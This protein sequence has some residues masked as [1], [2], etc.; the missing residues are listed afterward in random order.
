MCST[1]PAPASPSE[2]TAA[3]STTA[4]AGPGQCAAHRGVEGDN[5]PGRLLPVDC[6][7]QVGGAPSGGFSR[8]PSAPAPAPRPACTAGPAQ[9]SAHWHGSTGTALQSWNKTPS[10]SR[11][12][13]LG[14]VLQQPGALLRVGPPRQVAVQRNN[15]SA[16]QVERVV[17]RHRLEA[18]LVLEL[19]A[20]WEGR[21][22]SALVGRPERGRR[23]AGTL[24]GQRI[25]AAP[26]PAPAAPPTGK[27]A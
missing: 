3:G 17:A 12:P 15:M 21:V 22:A 9:R 23:A 19:A 14:Q 8:A 24:S 18:A 11:P 26:A 20:G 10:T 2:R 16:R 7:Q 5:Q 25:S 1:A 27:P 6:G 13:T 4:A